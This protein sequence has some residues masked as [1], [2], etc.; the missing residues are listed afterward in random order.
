MR[1]LIV[2]AAVIV[3]V[4]AGEPVAVM[5]EGAP[6]AVRHGQVAESRE[7]QDPLAVPGHQGL[8]R[9]FEVVSGLHAD[10]PE[11]HGVVEAVPVRSLGLH[12]LANF[13]GQVAGQGA[14]LHVFLQHHTGEGGPQRGILQG[15]T[16]F[17]HGGLSRFDASAGRGTSIRPRIA[18]TPV[19]LGQPTA[20]SS[21]QDRDNWDAPFILSPH[22]SKRL[23]F[24][25]QDVPWAGWSRDRGARSPLSVSYHRLRGLEPR[26]PD[27]RPRSSRGRSR[28]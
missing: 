4:V 15:G 24:G 14:D 16:G 7:D 6:L 12:F 10:G 3:R 17:G 18:T 11:I 26:G 1:S 13:R 8:F 20:G 28:Q 9:H 21:W 19:A 23:Y 5:E 2:P 27:S 25:S 22:D